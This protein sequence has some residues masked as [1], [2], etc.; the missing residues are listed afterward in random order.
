MRA[1]RVGEVFDC[2]E[3]HKA[4]GEAKQGAVA[5]TQGVESPRLWTHANCLA[6][7]AAREHRLKGLVRPMTECL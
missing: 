3:E 7:G 2:V 1:V 4:V 5:V 6:Y